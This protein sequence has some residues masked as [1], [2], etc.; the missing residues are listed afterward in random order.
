MIAASALHADCDTLWSEDMQ[1]GTVLDSRFHI[2]TR[3]RFLVQ[4]HQAKASVAPT[5][6][7]FKPRLV[8]YDRL[9]YLRQQY[10]T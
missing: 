2:A 9:G 5:H 4:R 8:Q 10:C 7:E 1:H 6:P 3:S